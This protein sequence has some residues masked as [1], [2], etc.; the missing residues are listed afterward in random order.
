MKTKSNL[1]LK[2]VELGPMKNYIYFLGN[3]T[4]K[5]VAVIDPAWETHKIFEIAAQEELEIKALFITHG[6]HDHTNGID[7]MLKELDIPVYVSK[8]EAEFYKPVSNNVEEVDQ[9]YEIRMGEVNI[10]FLHT[11]G[12]TPGSQCFY[13]ENK[14]ISGDTLFLDG[15][16]RCDLPGGNPEEMY[17]TIYSKLMKLPD[18]TII[19]PGHNYHELAE[20]T[21][22]NQRKTNPYMNCD[23]LQ[24]FLKKRM[25]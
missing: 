21:L 14:L 20:D 4:S 25:Y 6:H 23:H 13:V 3:S 24:S 8:H 16:G 12:H 5:E 1:Y 2:Q 9:N 19:Y 18:D 10:K 22:K 7:A 15:C 17:R 11:P